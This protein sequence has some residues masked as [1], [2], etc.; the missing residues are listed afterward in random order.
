MSTGDTSTPRKR[1]PEKKIQPGELCQVCN[2]QATGFNYG[3][4]TCNPC[5]SFFRRTVLENNL[6]QKCDRGGACYGKFIRR[7]IDCRLAKCELV[8]MN[9]DYIRDLRIRSI[10]RRIQKIPTNG[11]LMKFSETLDPFQENFLAIL[12][13]FW[14]IYRN[15]QANI[16]EPSLDT[17]GAVQRTAYEVVVN[18][19]NKLSSIKQPNPFFQIALDRLHFVKDVINLHASMM[20]VFLEAIPSIRW[21]QLQ[22]ETKRELITFG[23]MEIPLIRS[24]SRSLSGIPPNRGQFEG[25]GLR[26]WVIEDM[27]AI[28]EDFSIKLHPDSYETALIA[29]LA[30]TSPDRGISSAVDY[31]ILSNIQE[32]ILEILRIKLGI[33]RKQLKVLASYIAFLQKLREYSHNSS[34]EWWRFISHK[35]KI[36]MAQQQEKEVVRTGMDFVAQGRT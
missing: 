19:E 27:F 4:L 17:T 16:H 32:T 34:E 9:A 31:K 25:T 35:K 21:H 7:C 29:A 8:G 20:L 14:I 5:K 15:K 12:E 24:G 36:F 23:T 30:A 26:D 28:I 22:E 2:E 18:F 6:T 3:A 11:Q 13:G 33:D 10:R 1:G